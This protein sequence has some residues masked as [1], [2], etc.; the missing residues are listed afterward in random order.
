MVRRRWE[1][2]Y[3]GGEG[4]GEEQ[5][6]RIDGQWAVRVWETET[7]ERITLEARFSVLRY[8]ACVKAVAVAS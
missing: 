3:P 6:S 4:S 5:Q 7:V 8:A 1:R 2:G